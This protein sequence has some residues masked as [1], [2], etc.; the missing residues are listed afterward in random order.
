M[1]EKCIQ[2]ILILLLAFLGSY[3]AFA[4][5][6]V[7]VPPSFFAVTSSN[8]ETTS[9]GVTTYTPWWPNSTAGSSP[10]IS[11]GSIGKVTGAEWTN[12]EYDVYDLQWHAPSGADHIGYWTLPDAYM[13]YGL[14]DGF[15]NDAYSSGIDIMYTFMETPQWSTCL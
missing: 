1:K 10:A 6:P 15:A 14:L 4:Q 8:Y 5:S 2:F 11:A 12:I 7:S 9:G 3:P 13:S